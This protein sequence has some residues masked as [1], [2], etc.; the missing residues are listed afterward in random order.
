MQKKKP[1]GRK[2]EKRRYPLTREP[3]D[4]DSFLA[5]FM[6]DYEEGETMQSGQHRQS[7]PIGSWDPYL[8]AKLAVNTITASVR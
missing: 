8:L 4:L 1:E 7:L 5:N 3:L 2:M 6:E